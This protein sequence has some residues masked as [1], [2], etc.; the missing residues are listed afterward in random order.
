MIR[1]VVTFLLFILAAILAGALITYPVYLLLQE[2]ISI[3]Y[4]KLITHITLLSG[5]IVSALYL[6]LNHLFNCSAFGYGLH[7]H[8]FIR[9]ILSGFLIGLLIIAAVET[10][11]L[12]LGIH[13]SDPDLAINLQS[14]TGILLKALLIGIV[15]GFIEETLFR[16][17]L[18]SGLLQQTNVF[19]AV[20]LSSLVYAAVHFLKYR[21]LGPD[22][23]I[24]WYT[25]LDML[26]DAL[27]RFSD[28]VII[29]SFSTLF[30]FGVLLALIRIRNNNI[31]WCI[32][33]HAGV[34]AAIKLVRY[35]MD[36]VPENRYLFLVNDYN[37]LL[38]WLTFF[39]L[40]T[41]TV[42]YYWRNTHAD[43]TDT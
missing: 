43:H 21:A 3:P 37:N 12:I 25:G 33:I 36:H 27:F 10:C 18:L 1:A 40:S 35:L 31:A 15:V 39:F 13:V 4:H 26:P 8:R 11:L 6:R 7:H 9:N 34:V 24:N 16:G 42:I 20:F 28:P 5:L 2:V 38:G 32:G 19:I 30:M 41:I 17:A 29:D 14:I 22:T 23:E